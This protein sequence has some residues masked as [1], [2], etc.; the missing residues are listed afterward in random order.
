MAL[1]LISVVV[2]P[3]GPVTFYSNL[4]ELAVDCDCLDCSISQVGSVEERD[5]ADAGAVGCHGDDHVI[6]QG[7]AVVDDE[8]L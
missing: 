1:R 8:R 2:K 4:L 7:E 6:P 3:Y 5:G